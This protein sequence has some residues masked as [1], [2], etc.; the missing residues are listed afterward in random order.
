VRERHLRDL[1]KTCARKVLAKHGTASLDFETVYYVLSAD[2]NSYMD[3]QQAIN[4]RLHRELAKLGVEFAYPTQRLLVS[5]VEQNVDR[6][7]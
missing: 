3:I 5:S 7:A 1:A 2:Y 6:A 4:F